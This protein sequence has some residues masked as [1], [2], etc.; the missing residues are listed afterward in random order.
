MVYLMNIMYRKAY[1][2]STLDLRKYRNTYEHLVVVK[3]QKF[4]NSDFEEP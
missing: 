1:I 4:K 2:G 3:I